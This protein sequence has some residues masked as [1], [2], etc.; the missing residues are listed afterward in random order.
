MEIEVT[1]QPEDDS[2][3]DDDD[4][5]DVEPST[6]VNFNVTVNKGG[7][8]N[9]IF[10]CSSDGTYL[11]VLHVALEPASGEYEDS[12]YTGPVRASLLGKTQGLHD[13]DAVCLIKTQPH[14]CCAGVC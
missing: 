2:Y 13:C 14:T 4:S 5:G 6:D 7:D 11:E 1:N 12:V 3:E 8:Q 9:L 10:E